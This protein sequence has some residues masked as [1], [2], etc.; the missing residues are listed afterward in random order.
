MHSKERI[1]CWY[2]RHN[3]V[4]HSYCINSPDGLVQEVDCGPKEVEK[5]SV[6]YFYIINRMALINAIYCIKISLTFGA[7]HI[8]EASVL[9]VVPYRGVG[10]RRG[11]LGYGT[12]GMLHARFMS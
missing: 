8:G 12:A 5:Q 4:I 11:F 10:I 1:G 6:Q 9:A 3:V 2:Q 7:S